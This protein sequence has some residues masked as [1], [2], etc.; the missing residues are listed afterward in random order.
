MFQGERSLARSWWCCEFDKW[1]NWSWG[2][3]LSSLLPRVPNCKPR[4]LLSNPEKKASAKVFAMQPVFFVF[5]LLLSLPFCPFFLKKKRDL[6]W[7][8]VIQTPWQCFCLWTTRG[9]A[10]FSREKSWRYWRNSKWFAYSGIYRNVH[11]CLWCLVFNLLP[12][13]SF[14]II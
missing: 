11:S 14:H 5:I 4:K 7:N 1:R 10:Y 6:L 2:S 8:G 9:I 12:G 3:P 13:V